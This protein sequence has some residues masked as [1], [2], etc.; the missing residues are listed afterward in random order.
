[1]VAG[2]ILD[3]ARG[4]GLADGVAGARHH[5][6]RAFALQRETEGT[7][8]VAAEILAERRRLPGL[9]AVGRHLDGA[10]AVAAVPGDAANR[11]AR[12]HLGAVGVAGDQ[13]VDHDLGDRR[14][15]R[16]LL[17]DKAPP[18]ETCRPAPDRLRP[19]R[20]WSRA[21]SPR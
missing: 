12:S 10:D 18:W 7:E 4:L 8:R 2:R 9:A 1:M 15:G 5:G 17:R 19:S 14:V 16:G 21:W 20:N 11:G 3:Q 6:D 13:R